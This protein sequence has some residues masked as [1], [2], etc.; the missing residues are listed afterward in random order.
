MGRT[1]EFIVILDNGVR[2]R[3]YHKIQRGSVLSFAVQLEVLVG[4]KWKPVVRYD[5]AHGFAHT[6][7]FT[8]NG[9]SEKKALN[10]SFSSALTLAD[11]DINENWEEYVQKFLSG[12]KNR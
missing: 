10:L 5:S 8:L 7:L 9:K 3:H 4:D 6:D 2:K 11:W 1:V 12:G